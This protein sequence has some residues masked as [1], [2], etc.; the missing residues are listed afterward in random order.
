MQKEIVHRKTIENQLQCNAEELE[1]A[2]NHLQSLDRLK[3]L[4]IASMSHELRTP[5]NSI[6]GFTGVILQGMSGEL[7]DRQQDQLSRVY[8]SAKHLLL[9]ISDVIDISKIEAGR[10]EACSSDFS[11]KGLID[12]AVEN[13]LPQL[14]AKKM[15][16]DLQVRDNI[17][18]HTDRKRLLQCLINFLSNSVS[19]FINNTQND[20]KSCMSFP[21]VWIQFY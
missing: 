20:T 7:N 17:I 12:D 3:S 11:I 4:F 15:S 2:N 1:K 18:L 9:L 19:F 14:T 16:I 21:M 13:I 8:R 10:V 6:I 5:L